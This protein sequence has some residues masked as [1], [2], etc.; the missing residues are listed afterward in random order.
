MQKIIC[1]C[2]RVYS[3]HCSF[4]S[5]ARARPT[6]LCRATMRRSLASAA[7]LLACGAAASAPAVPS[8]LLRNSA[9][10]GQRLP[11]IGLGTGSYSD[12]PTVGYGGYPECW[13]TLAGCGAYTERAV[14]AWLAAGGRRIDAANSYGSQISVGRAMAASP[15]PREDVFLLSK[16]ASAASPLHAAR[17]RV[18]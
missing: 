6:R 15:V 13:S 5:L 10:P 18:V 4:V 7:L 2:A 17:T 9:A 8:V 1:V 12:D 14:G 3:S 16:G 11:A